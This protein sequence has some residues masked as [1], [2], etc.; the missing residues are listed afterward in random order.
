[1]RVLV[2]RPQEQGEETAARLARRPIAQ[3]DEAILAPVLSIVP[4]G[5]APPPG[6]FDA[7]LVTSRNVV[8]PLAAE[9]D[10]LANLPV[11][12]V[13]PRTGAALAA[14]GCRD[15]AVADGDAVSLA[16]LVTRRL[17]PGSALLHAA[18]RDRRA[19]PGATLAAAGFSVTTWEVYAAEPLAHLPEA[20]RTALAAG[21]VDAAL[22]YSPRSAA[23]AERLAREAGLGRAFADILHLCLSPNVADAFA[24]RPPRFMVAEEPSEASLLSLLHQ[25]DGRT[26]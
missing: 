6:P 16:V 9:P 14:A 3:S 18:G 7:L 13:G 11:F 21:A 5:T 2:F 26:D 8:P 22:H 19:E 17:R 25:E 20:A 24:A 12:A 1:M 23:I 10:L 15:V 4:T